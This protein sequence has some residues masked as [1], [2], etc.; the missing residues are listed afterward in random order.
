M[1]KS[2][3]IQYLLT[4]SKQDLR[5][6]KDFVHSPYFNKHQKTRELLD[7]IL[8]VKDM[9]SP[10]LQKEIVFKK[11]FPNMTYHEQTLR[12]TMSYLTQLVYRF[13]GQKY[14][15][16]NPTEQQLGLLEIALQDG[17]KKMF[18]KH[19]LAW[20][21]T[22]SQSTV[23]D[24]NYFFQASRFQH[25]Q[26]SFDL[27][28]GK[29]SSGNF[30]EKAVSNFNTYFIAEKLRMTCEMLARK[31]VT[32]QDYSFL[33]LKELI[34]FLEKEQLHFKSIT[35]V[36]VYFLIYKMITSNDPQY[37]FDLKLLLKE[38][39][40][41][42]K[43]QEGRD[44]Y[45]HALN[46]CIG[47]LNVGESNFKKETF[48]LYQ[49]M[50]ENGLLYIEN[51]IHQWDYTNI[52]SLGCDFQESE[53]TLNFISEQKH[54]LLEAQRENTYNYN[55]A[56]YHYSKQEYSEAIQLLQN[57]EF[58]E[59]YNSVLT[60]ILML[61]IYFEIRDWQALDYLL[62]TFRIYLIR[63]KQ[64]EENRR[65]SGLNLIKYTRVLSRLLEAK[66]SLSKVDFLNKKNTLQRQ[67]EAEDKVLQKSWLLKII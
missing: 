9:E 55:L 37:F 54:Y 20:E 43:H 39:V 40:H 11:V 19:S 18:K 46:Y 52:V 1:Q 14:H 4:F 36:W 28:F 29:R 8:N 38:D 22:Q 56:A 45:T 24:S 57:V 35:G 63:T 25:M 27:N 34:V 61:K 15:D 51:R 42:F 32:G 33:F 50:V 49:Q 10:L 62:E 64:L 3:L 30:L 41:L 17:Q 67:I 5:S 53:W 31:Q 60:R 44:L 66:D 59:I 2:K 6:F 16:S 26:N 58:N 7:Y 47:K 21:K 48:E 65:K 12:T 23:R 13:Y